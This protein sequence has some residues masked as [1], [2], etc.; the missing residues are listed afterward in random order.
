LIAD[1]GCGHV[2]SPKSSPMTCRMILAIFDPKDGCAP[3]FDG[4][5]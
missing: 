4:T 3:P 5:A 2:K 1:Y